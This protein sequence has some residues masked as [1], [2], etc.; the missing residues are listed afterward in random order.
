MLE[1]DE[2]DQCKIIDP[3]ILKNARGK[4]KRNQRKVIDEA[5]SGQRDVKRSSTI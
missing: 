1:L 2:N 5:P 4:P 3:S